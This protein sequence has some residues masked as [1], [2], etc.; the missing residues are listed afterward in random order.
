MLVG[1]ARKAPGDALKAR[2]Q[3]V[4][5]E[6]VK[7]LAGFPY[8]GNDPAAIR[9]ACGT[10]DLPGG[11]LPVGVHGGK[12]YVVLLGGPTLEE[13]GHQKGHAGL[14][15]VSMQSLLALSEAVSDASIWSTRVE[16]SHRA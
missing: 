14:L 15:G 4:N 6:L 13:V 11:K 8:S 10:R 9:R 5:D 3:S 16:N 12:Q 1:A 7:C 2:D